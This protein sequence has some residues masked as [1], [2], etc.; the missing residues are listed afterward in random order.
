[1]TSQRYFPVKC[2]KNVAVSMVGD[3]KVAIRRR[4]TDLQSE[5]LLPIVNSSDQN[6]LWKCIRRAHVDGNENKI[7]FSSD[8]TSG[9]LGEGTYAIFSPKSNL[10]VRLYTAG[11]GK[12]NL[13]LEKPVKHKTGKRMK[14][15]RV[16]K[17]FTQVHVWIHCLSKYL[18]L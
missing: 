15:W 11:C 6:L 16:W 1:M 17:V 7:H 14:V 13:A 2:P 10:S 9:R 4:T 18:R 8:R 3:I 5:T 12:C